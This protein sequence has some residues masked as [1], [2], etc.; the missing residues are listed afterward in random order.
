MEKYRTPTEDDSSTQN[1]NR[2]LKMPI[3]SLMLGGAQEA[4]TPSLGTPVKCPRVRQDEYGPDC[5]RKGDSWSCRVTILLCD[6]AC[7]RQA[8]SCRQPSL[9]FL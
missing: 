2:L 8:E 4:C 1:L 9:R 3:L 7:P 6:R 5:N